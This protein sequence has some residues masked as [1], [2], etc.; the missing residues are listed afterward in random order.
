MTSSLEGEGSEV[1]HVYR[2]DVTYD[3]LTKS[4]CN[5][6]LTESERF[7]SETFH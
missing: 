3:L 4:S 5:D 1:K 7:M 2:T 6:R